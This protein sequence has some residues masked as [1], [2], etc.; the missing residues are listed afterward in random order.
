M[1]Y[2]IIIPLFAL[3]LFGVG[4]I[5]HTITKPTASFKAE[6][7]VSQKLDA[8]LEAIQ[9]DIDNYTEPNFDNVKVSETTDEL[10]K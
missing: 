1:N 8:E 6:S 5:T 9:G 3:V 4:F 7:A 2:K 10:I